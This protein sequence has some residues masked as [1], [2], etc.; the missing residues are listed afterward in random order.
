MF[1]NQDKYQLSMSQA[2]WRAGRNDIATFEMFY[3]TKD[4]YPEAIDSYGV[5]T[6]I[7]CPPAFPGVYKLVE[8]NGEPK[9]KTSINKSTQPYKKR[10][11][12]CPDGTLICGRDA[13]GENLLKPIG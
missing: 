4:V 8:L 5:G 11:V 2:W 9:Q 1:D 10:V 13:V 3:R 12:R 7:T 6:A